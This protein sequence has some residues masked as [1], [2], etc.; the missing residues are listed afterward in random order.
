MNE[1]FKWC[2]ALLQYYAKAFHTTYET[3]NVWIFCI[4][5][6]IVFLFMLIVIVRQF[7][8]IRTLKKGI[9]NAK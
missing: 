6:P 7:F 8:K 4:I 3:L 9:G 2:V 5:E 1:I